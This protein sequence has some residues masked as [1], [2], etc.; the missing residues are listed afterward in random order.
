MLVAE[1]SGHENTWYQLYA[2]QYVCETIVKSNVLLWKN[3][4]VF[5]KWKG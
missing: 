1:H 2:E 4:L 5:P 3:I